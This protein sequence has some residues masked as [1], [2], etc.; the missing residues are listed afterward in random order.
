[1]TADYNIVFGDTLVSLLV[2][3]SSPFLALAR[4]SRDIRALGANANQRGDAT[5]LVV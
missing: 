5:G 4:D 1:M 3:P 2:R